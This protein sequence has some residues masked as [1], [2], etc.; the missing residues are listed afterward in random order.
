MIAKLGAAEKI[1]DQMEEELH[2]K[3]R[4]LEAEL[5]DEDEII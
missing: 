5:S 3:L 4:E 2:Q 1:L